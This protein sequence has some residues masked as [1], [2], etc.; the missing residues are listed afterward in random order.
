MFDKSNIFIIIYLDL[1]L[2]KYGLDKRYTTQFCQLPFMNKL[3]SLS[4][5]E[6]QPQVS[7]QV[8]TKPL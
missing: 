7:T 5:S 3:P 6:N 2:V 1:D 4:E 8:A